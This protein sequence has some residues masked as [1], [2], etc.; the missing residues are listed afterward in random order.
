MSI[1]D[2]FVD[3]K[4][5]L[6]FYSTIIGNTSHA[7]Q[8]NL[9]GLLKEAVERIDPE[10]MFDR[11]DPPTAY[12]IF[13][14]VEKLEDANVRETIDSPEGIDEFALEYSVWD[15][16]NPT[17]DTNQFPDTDVVSTEDRTN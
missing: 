3:L 13:L 2:S 8:T 16:L 9:F 15:P 12:E 10:F 11:D 5:V 7:E 4:K 17:D 14:I 6:I 1:F